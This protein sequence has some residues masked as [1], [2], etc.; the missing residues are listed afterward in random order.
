MSSEQNA[1]NIAANRR[2][3]FD[4]ESQVANNRVQ[5]YE[6]RALINEN[7]ALL[8]KNIDSLGVRPIGRD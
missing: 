6:T 1:A 4:V 2:A 7:A 8:R 3:I 5:A